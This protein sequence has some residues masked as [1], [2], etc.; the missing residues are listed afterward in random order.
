MVEVRTIEELQAHLDNLWP[1]GCA[2]LR[3]EIYATLFAKEG[4][5]PDQLHLVYEFARSL[6]CSVIHDPSGGII[7]F[8]KWHS[9]FAA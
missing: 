8:E 2:D 4:S 3:R 6:S 1:G 7:R 9:P 5:N